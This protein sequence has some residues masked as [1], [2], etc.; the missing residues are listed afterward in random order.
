MYLPTPLVL[1]LVPLRLTL[2]ARCPL[3]RPSGPAGPSQLQP[4]GPEARGGNDQGPLARLPWEGGSHHLRPARGP[5]AVPASRCSGMDGGL[6]GWAGL[7]PP[8][9]AGLC[10]LNRAGPYRTCWTPRGAHNGPVGRWLGRNSGFS[11]GSTALVV[12]AFHCT[13]RRQAS[14]MFVSGQEW[15]QM[16]AM[17]VLQHWTKQAVTIRTLMIPRMARFLFAMTAVINLHGPMCPFPFHT[18]NRHGER[19]W[20]I[21]NLVLSPYV[22]TPRF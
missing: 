9:V 19:P 13:A 3:W 17:C 4:G 21:A 6:L 1:V 14:C 15:L 16:S 12:V 20:V 10:D 22:H 8:R 5:D 18:P 7:V 11:R 2:A